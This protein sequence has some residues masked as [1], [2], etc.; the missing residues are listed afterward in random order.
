MKQP[1]CLPDLHLSL[2]RVPGPDTAAP[3]HVERP[4]LHRPVAD[5]AE[6]LE[7]LLEARHARGRAAP[8]IVVVADAPEHVRLASL[9]A[10][11]AVDLKGLLDLFA[12]L[13]LFVRVDRDI[14]REAERVVVERVRDLL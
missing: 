12:A 13:A 4:R 10:D 5:A 8:E 7:R 11:L 1:E 14:D 9:V 2:V 6:D 3:G